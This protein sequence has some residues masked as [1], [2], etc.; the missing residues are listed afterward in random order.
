M[1]RNRR[2][3][4]GQYEYTVNGIVYEIDKI[5]GFFRTRWNIRRKGGKWFD[6]ASTLREA[7][8]W[9]END[10]VTGSD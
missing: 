1:T 7:K 2:I 4:Q 3:C 6:A 10:A 5:E 9:A 8:I